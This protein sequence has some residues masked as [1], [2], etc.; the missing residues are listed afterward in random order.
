MEA[1]PLSSTPIFDIHVHLGTWQAEELQSIGSDFCQFDQMCQRYGVVGAAVTTT[2]GPEDCVSRNRA[3]LARIKGRPEYQ[4]FPW[5]RI[6]DP[7][8]FDFVMESKEWIRGFKVHPA[9]D[10]VPFDDKAFQPLLELADEMRVPI[11]V[12][13]GHWKEMTSYEKVLPAAEKFPGV[14]FI[15]AHTTGGSF[16]DRIKGV[17]HIRETG[18]EN[19]YVDIT[20]SFRWKVILWTIEYLTA[21]KV[22]FGSDFPLGHPN[23][24]RGLMETIELTREERDAIYFQN[25]QRLLNKKRR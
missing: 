4:F 25:G 5:I 19:L 12:H 6:Q 7:G 9:L 3:L 13:C 2:D 24:Y 10:R 18:L 20:G 11:L 15:L 23:L 22:L 1:S 21:Y 8:I 16:V 14:D 17:K